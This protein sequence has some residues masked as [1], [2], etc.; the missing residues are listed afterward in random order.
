MAARIILRDELG[1]R[2]EEFRF[3]WPWTSG[4]SR[5]SNWL[6]LRKALWVGKMLCAAWLAVTPKSV[7][8]AG[9]VE[10]LG[11]IF[12][13]SVVRPL[14][15]LIEGYSVRMMVGKV[16]SSRPIPFVGM[17]SRR[18]RGMN[19]IVFLCLLGI[20]RVVIWKTGQEKFYGYEKWSSS[21]LIVL[22][23]INL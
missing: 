19:T 22:L 16:S 1:L 21:Q 20:M 18:W 11:H 3:P 9:S 10:T 15:E 8:C 23:I 2:N 5:L 12:H 13:C 17:L 6:V 14:W 7:R 4:F